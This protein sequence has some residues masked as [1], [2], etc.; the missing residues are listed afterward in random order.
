MWR[1][2][3]GLSSVMSATESVTG[4]LFFLLLLCSFFPAFLFS[5][6]IFLVPF[7]YILFF[8]FFSVI[9]FL[10]RTRQASLDMSTVTNLKLVMQQLKDQHTDEVIMAPNL[11]D[12]VRKILCLELV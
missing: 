9:N 2:R 5:I 7:S 8:H 6:F 10:F 11:S 1:T 4:S 12:K 3:L